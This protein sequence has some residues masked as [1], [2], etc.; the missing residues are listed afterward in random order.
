MNDSFYY[1]FSATPQV[2]GGVLALF[3][4]FVVFK[5]QMLKDQM[6]GIEKAIT[7]D[8]ERIILRTQRDDNQ[9]LKQYIL[10]A[11]LSNDIERCKIHLNE[12]DY[13]YAF[14]YRD[15]FN[16]IYSSYKNLISNT[17]NWSIITAAVI[18]LCLMTIPFG[19]FFINHHCLLNLL[20]GIVIVGII[21]CFSGLI[22]ILK[23][24][25]NSNPIRKDKATK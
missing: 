10:N 9:K 1:F 22:Y 11:T 7:K 8:P 21:V 15:S 4:V 19:E 25:L 23:T 16:S 2:L 24:A 20:F 14:Y 17:I 6:I 12:I 5:I 18:I 3:G 13:Q